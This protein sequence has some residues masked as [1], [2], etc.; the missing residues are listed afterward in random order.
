MIVELVSVPPTDIKKFAYADL[1]GIAACNAGILLSLYWTYGL[2]SFV[3][4]DFSSD[5]TYVSL[6]PSVGLAGYFIGLALLALYPRA[7]LVLN[8]K[9]Q[10]LLLATSLALASL[11]Q[12]ILQLL[13]VCFIIGLFCC[14]SQR[15]IG[16][17]VQ[18]APKGEGRK[19]VASLI[20]AAL[21]CLLIFRL[22][23]HYLATVL[24]WRG[25]SLLL[26]LVM[27]SISIGANTQVRS[28]I[29]PSGLLAGGLREYGGRERSLLITVVTR[30][31]AIF[32]V[33]Q[34]AWL[35][36]LRQE[37]SLAKV[38]MTISA[39]L[40]GIATA[41]VVRCGRESLVGGRLAQWLLFP[42]LLVCI[43][44]A[45]LTTCTTT[46]SVGFLIAICAFWMVEI[47]TQ[48]GT[49]TNQALIQSLGGD[50]GATGGAVVTIAGALGGTLGAATLP[51]MHQ[52][53]GLCLTAIQLI[54]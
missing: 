48:H 4:Q 49:V 7:I 30:Q 25:L 15:L 32:F 18:R 26:A 3:L 6:L 1:I 35:A 42:V 17:A 8:I 16:E 29:I 19:A 11:A 36:L 34:S 13:L 52:I 41:V 2:G 44:L 46:G 33:Y 50:K 5:S 51:S 53:G 37:S 45:S 22:S 43:F 20:S 40:I 38:F 21:T 47:T 39:G 54:R 23:S 10:L 9:Y 27:A 28:P 14:A 31:F 12:D 24:S